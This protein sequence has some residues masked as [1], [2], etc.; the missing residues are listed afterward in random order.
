MQFWP[1]QEFKFWEN[2]KLIA[3]YV[4]GLSYRCREGNDRL[5]VLLAGGSLPGPH[6]V[7]IEMPDLTLTEIKPSDVVEGWLNTGLCSLV[8]P[9]GV[10]SGGTVEGS[11]QTGG[12]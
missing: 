5:Q 8:P 12:N 10:V 4:P 9:P 7:Y 1:V 11:A 2:D 3:H 6:P